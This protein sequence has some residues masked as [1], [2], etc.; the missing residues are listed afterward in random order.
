MGGQTVARR[1]GSE[2]RVTRELGRGPN[3][4]VW[5]GEGPDG[6][7]AVKLLRAELAADEALVARFVRERA[8]LTALDHP[9][10][11]GVR[12]LVADGGDLAIVMDLVAGTDLRRRLSPAGG[13]GAPLPPALAA[14]IAADIASGLAAAHAAGILHRD[15]KP[16]NV[17]L[18]SVDESAADGATTRARV[19]DTG[20][21]RLVEGPPSDGPVRITGTPDYLA[22][23]LVEGCQPGPPVDVYALGTL[24]FEM[25]AGWTPF[26]GG[27]R[28]AVLRRHV[29]EHVPGLSGCPAALAEIVNS[30]LSKGPAARLTAPEVAERLRALAPGLVR[31]HALRLDDPRRA[32]RAGATERD[33][34]AGA[35]EKAAARGGGSRA[36][37]VPLVVDDEHRE[38]GATH[39]NLMK[40]IREASADA[41]PA[42]EKAAGPSRRRRGLTATIVVVLLAAVTASVTYL[43]LRDHAAQESRQEQA[44]GTAPAVTTT[45]TIIETPS[46]TPGSAPVFDPPTDLPA[47]PTTPVG[48]TRAVA[49]GSGLDAFVTGADGSLWFTHSEGEGFGAWQRISGKDL[50]A[51]PSV[52]ALGGHAVLIGLATDGALYVR[53]VSGSTPDAAWQPMPMPYWHPVMTGAPGAA[54][55]TGGAIALVVATADGGLVD[56]TGVPGDWHGWFTPATDTPLSPGVAVSGASGGF[57]AYVLRRSD[58]MVLDVPY[59][60]GAW[61]TATPIGTAASGTPQAMA[62]DGTRYVAVRRAGGAVAVFRLVGTSWQGTSTGLTSAG[63]PGACALPDGHLAVVGTEGRRARLA[64]SH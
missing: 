13:P 52:V 47:L 62:A 33:A 12:D 17:L 27:S 38:A 56:T 18:S 35:A 20:I 54:V 22:P 25:L 55:I 7:I 29:T 2:Y 19:S 16:E 57:D 26:G 24:L 63:A 61:G 41:Q 34:S 51:P 45:T 48:G 64:T 46:A 9:N 59:R 32:D 23:E 1:I 4:T 21:A 8:T 42:R 43:A 14:S 39:F 6:A 60:H 50:S 10:L 3:G 40:P 15:L 28:G 5:I 58:G 37:V 36:T 31:R 53:T 30:C 44:A 11:V 49:V